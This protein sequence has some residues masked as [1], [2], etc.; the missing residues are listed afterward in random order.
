MDLSFLFIHQS[1]S[2]ATARACTLPQWVRSDGAASPSTAWDCRG[3]PWSHREIFWIQPTSWDMQ[4]QPQAIP[5]RMRRGRHVAC[6]TKIQVQ[7]FCWLEKSLQLILG[8]VL[9]LWMQVLRTLVVIYITLFC[10]GRPSHPEATSSAE[11]TSFYLPPVGDNASLKS[12]SGIYAATAPGA[13]ETLMYQRHQ[14]AQARLYQP[15]QPFPKTC[16]GWNCLQHQKALLQLT[17]LAHARNSCT[18]ARWGFCNSKRK[19]GQREEGKEAASG[20]ESWQLHARD[21]CSMNP[22]KGLQ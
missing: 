13:E 2:A 19:A 7:H 20:W 12:V 22:R 10:K 17:F 6:H 3:W 14:V 1:C 15:H 21:F 8:V 5:L 16:K 18:A 4:W 9:R 11:M